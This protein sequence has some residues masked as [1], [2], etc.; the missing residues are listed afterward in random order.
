MDSYFLQACATIDGAVVDR[1]PHRFLFHYSIPLVSPAHVEIITLMFYAAFEV[2]AIGTT[3]GIACLHN[4][5]LQSLIHC[6]IACTIVKEFIHFQKFEVIVIL[7]LA[8]TA[9]L[10]HLALPYHELT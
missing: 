7:W 4:R 1:R 6:D 2:S 3:I 9:V 8:F 10:H 5:A